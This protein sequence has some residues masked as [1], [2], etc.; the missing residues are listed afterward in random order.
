MTSRY[1]RADRPEISPAE[2]YAIARSECDATFSDPEI[3]RKF[4]KSGLILRFK[5]YW[6][7]SWS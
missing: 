6:S 1:D 7:W 2:M 3:A 4:G 5:Y